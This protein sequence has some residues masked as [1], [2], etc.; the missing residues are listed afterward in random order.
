MICPGPRIS[1]RTRFVPGS[2]VHA[3]E[4]RPLISQEEKRPVFLFLIRESSSIIAFFLFVL[5]YDTR[6]WRRQHVR[7]IL[8]SQQNQ[9]KTDWQFA[10]RFCINDCSIKVNRLGTGDGF[11]VSAYA[12]GYGTSGE[13]VG[14]SNNSQP[15]P[16]YVKSF[17]TAPSKLTTTLAGKVTEAGIVQVSKDVF[18]GLTAQVLSRSAI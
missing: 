8:W 9:I 14:V 17:T 10:S 4:F 15:D 3:S 2:I 16:S 13:G 18:V 5:S 12:A 6:R 1:A 11:V 7:S